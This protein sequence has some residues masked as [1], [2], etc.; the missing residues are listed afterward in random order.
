MNSNAS[1]YLCGS[2]DI[3]M[4][5]GSVRDDSTLQ[6]LECRS[7]GLVFLSSFSHIGDSFYQ[8]S[9]MHG[10]NINIVNWLKETEWDDERRFNMLKQKMANKHILDFGGGAG[11]F[12]KKAKQI[13]NEV[14][15]VELERSVEQHYLDNG[16]RLYTCVEDIPGEEK[17]DLITAFHVIE[18]IKK[19][20]TILNILAGK[21]NA[22]GKII[23]EVPNANDA[24]LTLYN[25]NAFMKFTYW[26]CHLYL[27]NSNTVRLLANK[28]GLKIIS[29]KHIQRYPLSNHLF[30]LAKE[31]PG[32]HEQWSFL[33]SETLNREYENQLAALGISDTILVEL[34]Q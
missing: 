34:E 6:V 5:E 24:L 4:R 29:I 32:G 14:S 20:D 13:C 8:D 16:I 26:S 19:P 22:N 31:K 33:D 17:Y 3:T 2:I 12:V 27:F 30:W 7:C 9:N 15:A 1:C 18:H 10:E 11:G 25:S 21:L 28:A 23:I